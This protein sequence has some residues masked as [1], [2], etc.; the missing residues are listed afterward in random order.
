MKTSKFN[1]AT[2]YF[3]LTCL[4]FAFRLAPL[5]TASERLTYIDELDTGTLGMEILHGMKLPVQAY[6]WDVYA[7][8]CLVLGAAAA[9]FFKMFGSHLLALKL[10]PLFFSWASFSILFWFMR[11][12]FGPVAA[13][14]CSLL[15]VFCPPAF[16]QLSL[17]PMAGR[18]EPLFLGAAVLF[19]FYEYFY[20]RN[21]SNRW[22]FLFG[23]VSAAAVWFYYANLIVVAACVTAWIYEKRAS[24]FL[25]SFAPALAGFLLGIAPALILGNHAETSAG[26]FFSSFLQP[27][28]SAETWALLPRKIA[29]IFLKDLPAAYVFYGAWGTPE[30]ILSGLFFLLHAG[31]FFLSRK[32]KCLPLILISVFTVLSLFFSGFSI[33][34][35]YGFVGVR[36][37]SPWFFYT[38]PVIAVFL[39]AAKWRNKIL[40]AWIG[41]S[42]FSHG[43]LWGKEPFARAQ[44]Y[45]G[46]SY[47]HLGGRGLVFL[48]PLVKTPDDFIRIMSRFSREQ[49]Y[50]FY[51]GMSWFAIDSG[52]G[53][54][55]EDREI[56]LSEVAGRVDPSAR[57]FFQEWMDRK[58]L[59]T[60]VLPFGFYGYPPDLEKNLR[61]NFA[62]KPEMLNEQIYRDLGWTVREYFGEDRARGLD[63]ISR[64]PLRFRDAGMQGFLACENERKIPDA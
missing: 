4:F 23:V 34:S 13:V 61:E 8:E 15:L 14:I 29:R 32:T 53:T 25:K 36:Y 60:P 21:L 57:I 12:F 55:L 31:L 62:S 24:S 50:F 28:L 63:W 1:P 59:K 58:M 16:T 35:I 11:R 22:A 19:V 40:A 10:V 9:F 26:F 48:R 52:I 49:R 44:N 39:A 20:R 42:L 54:L 41:L 5:L 45:R 46:Y 2:V 64:F 27:W 56:P 37:L 43:G 3:F 7:G 51:R 17:L 47:Q 38:C 6:Q 33:G 18:T 30:K